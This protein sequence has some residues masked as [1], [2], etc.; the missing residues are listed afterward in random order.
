[1]S[2][3]TSRV[4]LPLSLAKIT[5]TCDGCVAHCCRYVAVEIETP[6]SRWQFDQVRWLLLH[7]NVAVYVGTDRRW[8]VEFRTKCRALGDDHRCTIYPERPD[9]C[10]AYEVKTCPRWASGKAYLVRFESDREYADYLALPP[11]ERPG[12]R[13][14][15][16][17][18]VSRPR[19]RPARVRARSGGPGRARDRSPRR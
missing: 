13:R 17:K 6:R 5:P 2:N 11:A 14:A 9:L 4:V 1:M 7:E 10:R 12:A 18:P 16:T 3:D 15:S 8:Y 19:R